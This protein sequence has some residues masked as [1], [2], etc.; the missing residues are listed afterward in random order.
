MWPS[1]FSLLSCSFI[2]M[3]RLRRK[4]AGIPFWQMWLLLIRD[5]VL[6]LQ[7]VSTHMWLWRGTFLHRL[8]LGLSRAG[9]EVWFQLISNHPTSSLSCDQSHDIMSPSHVAS[10]SV[11]TWAGQQDFSDPSGLW[12]YHLDCDLL[13][14]KQSYTSSLFFF[15]NQLL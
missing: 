15:M 4:P 7:K 10:L 3:P 14:H 8:T 5:S 13:L 9:E 2:D 1:C 12:L 11:M 6:G